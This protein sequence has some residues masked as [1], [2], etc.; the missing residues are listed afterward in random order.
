MYIQLYALFNVINITLNL[1]DERSAWA[2]EYVSSKIRIL[3]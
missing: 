3:K 1:I 2:E